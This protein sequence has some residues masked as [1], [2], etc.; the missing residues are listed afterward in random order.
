MKVK[1]NKKSITVSEIYGEDQM[2]IVDEGV[3]VSGVNVTYSDC[4]TK[5][6]ITGINEQLSAFVK[7]WNS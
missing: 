2:E 5:A 7:F 1:S 3:E 6:K 4:S